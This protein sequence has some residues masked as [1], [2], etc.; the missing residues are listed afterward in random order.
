MAIRLHGGVR[1]ASGTDEIVEWVPDARYQ[2]PFHHFGP[3]RPEEQMTR[4]FLDHL[5]HLG[6]HLE[7]VNP[8]SK[9]VAAHLKR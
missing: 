6:G 7:S 4:S 9:P 1:N 8:L 3:P 2:R 5:D